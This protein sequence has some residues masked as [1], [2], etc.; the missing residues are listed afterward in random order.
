MSDEVP[1]IEAVT[2]E[3]GA[4]LRRGIL[5][6]QDGD[7]RFDIDGIDLDDMLDGIIRVHV[8]PLVPEDRLADDTPSLELV[9]RLE[10]HLDEVIG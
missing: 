7:R 5:H 6:P 3:I 1:G 10:V 9:V 8:T 2:S 4:I